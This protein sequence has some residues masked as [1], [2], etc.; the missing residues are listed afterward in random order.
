MTFGDPAIEFKFLGSS[1][2]INGK[3]S[4]GGGN[5][6]VLTKS[7][8]DKIPNDWSSDGQ[9]IVYQTSNPKTKWDLWVLPMSGDRQPLPFLQTEFN[10]G[11]AQFSPD[12][13]W[14]IYTSD[15][16]GAPEVY[17]Q[18]FPSS[19]GKWR[20]STDGGAQ[21]RWRKDGR[22]LFYIA[23]DRTLMAVEVK[24]GD[25]FEASVP[26]PLFG[27]RVV[28]LTEFRNHYVVTRDGE[29]FLINST[30]EETT[31]TPINVI[32]NWTA[33]LNR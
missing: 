2:A 32:V 29:R 6:E 15:E 10:E 28:S 31:A 22:E 24:L 3:I 25:T 8:E 27:T 19:E 16:S 13:K 26:K 20:V 18:T 4:G 17:V 9:F 21:P 12:G 7:S 33:D 14:I 11:Q 1:A 30:L 23:S 5:E